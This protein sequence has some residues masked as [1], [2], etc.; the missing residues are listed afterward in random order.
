MKQ[1]ENSLGILLEQAVSEGEISLLN[2]QNKIHK[3][4]I[5]SK[6]IQKQL[7]PSVEIFKEIMVELIRNKEIDIEKIK[8]ERS[9]FIQE[10]TEDFQL[11]EM[12]LQLSESRFADQKIR[13]IEVYR[14]EDGNTVTF[15]NVQTEVGETKRIR[16][17]NIL[18]RIVRNEE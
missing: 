4:E 14:I 6:E 13:K 3:D 8:R 5:T 16:C 10:Q 11:S 18:I 9:E 17:S 12:L 15:D 7:I 2:L 1:Y